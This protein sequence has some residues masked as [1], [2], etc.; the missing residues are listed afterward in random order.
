[1]STAPANENFAWWP[2]YLALKGH[3]PG[4]EITYADIEAEYGLDRERVHRHIRRATRHLEVTEQRTVENVIGTGYRIAQAADHVTLAK[5]QNRLGRKRIQRGIEIV[6]S[7]NLEDLDAADRRR[8]ERFSEHQ[9]NLM[10]E[11][12]RRP[13]GI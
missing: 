2:L 5:R 13:R 9:A 1:M 12:S 4:D 11:M 10:R 8:H 6:A 7:T 3:V